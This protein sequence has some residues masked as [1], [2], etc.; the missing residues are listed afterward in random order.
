MK[1]KKISYPTPRG[2]KCL[3]KL[4]IGYKATFLYSPS[5]IFPGTHHHL[6]PLPLPPLHHPTLS[7]HPLFNH[8]PPI[9]L[10]AFLIPLLTPI[11]VWNRAYMY[12][13]PF[14]CVF[15]CFVQRVLGFECI[16][17]TLTRYL[18]L[19]WSTFSF[20]VG[21]SLALFHGVEGPVGEARLVCG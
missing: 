9:S 15:L 3:I 8:P 7:L 20:E 10:P 21:V 1:K 11:R 5:S 13:L 14:F 16:C 17:T 6:I 18:I 12:T 4:G 19:G 2:K